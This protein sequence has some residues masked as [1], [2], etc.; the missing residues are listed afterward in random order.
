MLLTDIYFADKLVNAQFGIVTGLSLLWYYPNSYEIEY[1]Y[2]KCDDEG[3]GLSLQVQNNEE[4]ENCVYIQRCDGKIPYR[5]SSKIKKTLAWTYSV[6]QAQDMTLT[7]VV[8]T[9]ELFI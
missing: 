7:R 6:Y 9:S 4:C 8:V 5:G 3:V 2:I 1:I